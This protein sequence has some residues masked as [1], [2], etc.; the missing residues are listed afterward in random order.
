[1]FYVRAVGSVGRAPALQ[2]GGREFES[3]TVHKF[4]T[5]FNK[6]LVFFDC[7]FLKNWL[8]Y[9]YVLIKMLIFNYEE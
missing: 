2:A 8:Y 6:N 9:I 3:P 4:K 7:N 1:M 5:R